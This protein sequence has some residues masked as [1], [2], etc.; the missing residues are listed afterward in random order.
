MANYKTQT[1]KYKTNKKN[2]N[3]SNTHYFCQYFLVVVPRPRPHCSLHIFFFFFFFWLFAQKPHCLLFFLFFSSSSSSSLLVVPAAAAPLIDG[4]RVAAAGIV[5]R[6]QSRLGVKIEWEKMKKRCKEDNNKDRLFS[7]W[8]ASH[9]S[10]QWCA[11]QC[12]KKEEEG[13]EEKRRCTIPH[14]HH[15]QV[16]VC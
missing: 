6:H 2:L 10:T 16:F 11:L 13:E 9:Q 1:A 5:Y 15:H 4:H 12:Q 3:F 8:C 14:C 7:F